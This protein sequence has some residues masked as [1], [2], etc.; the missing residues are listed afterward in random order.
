M[1][2]AWASLSTRLSRNPDLDGRCNKGRFL[3][4]RVSLLPS[5]QRSWRAFPR[6][7]RL[8]GQPGYGVEEL[9][10]GMYVAGSRAQAG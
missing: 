5:G 6:N 4:E 8:F 10:P 3:F 1:V 2:D 7:A 9:G